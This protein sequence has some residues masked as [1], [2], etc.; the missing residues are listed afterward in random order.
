MTS[1]TVDLV[2]IYRDDGAWYFA[3][4]A[5]REYDCSY[6]LDAETARE[7]REEVE[8]MFP[9]AKVRRLKEDQL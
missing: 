6:E 8:A 2:Y 4:W 1:S 5:G 9:G 7:A 3:A